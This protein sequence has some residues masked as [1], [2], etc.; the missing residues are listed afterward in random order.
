MFHASLAWWW[1]AN[2][3]WLLLSYAGSLGP[4]A[5]EQASGPGVWLGRSP[6]LP[7]GGGRLDLVA[8]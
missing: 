6:A 1:Q 2:G 4:G 7:V 8:V 5:G 3:E